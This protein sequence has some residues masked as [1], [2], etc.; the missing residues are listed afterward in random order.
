MSSPGSTSSYDLVE[1]ARSGDEDAYQRLFEKYHRRLALFAHYRLGETL[2]SSMDVDDVVQET[3]LEASRDIARF[4]YRSPDS[5]FRW[6]ASIA[7]HVIE[8]A[9]RRQS[10]RKRDGGERVEEAAAQMVDTLTPSRIL[11]QSEKI[12][13]LMER[14]DKLPPQYREVIVLSKLEGL[15]PAE[16][17]K[18][19]DKPRDAVALLLHRALKRFRS[20]INS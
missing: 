1:L 10:R 20:E 12:Q 17:A 7:R 18:R 19:L 14:L 15:A 8:D 3:F 6:L 2:R 4:E 5:F 13:A 16:I 11:F 9:A